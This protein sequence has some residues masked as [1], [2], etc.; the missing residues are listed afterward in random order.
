MSD[1]EVGIRLTNVPLMGSITPTA[2]IRTTKSAGDA[3]EVVCGEY[4]AET[5]RVVGVGV[6]TVEV[7]MG[8]ASE[9]LVVVVLVFPE[10]V[11][12]EENHPPERLK[13]CAKP[14]TTTSI[15]TIEIAPATI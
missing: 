10:G 12:R 6:G 7:R 2:R 3:Y 9:V 4:V 13:R 5:A 1:G 14:H 15:T 8:C 11:K